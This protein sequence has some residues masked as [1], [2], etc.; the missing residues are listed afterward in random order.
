MNLQTRIPVRTRR[1][2]DQLPDFEEMDQRIHHVPK[3]V[4]DLWEDAK[5]GVPINLDLGNALR[6][7]LTEEMKESVTGF[8]I[9]GFRHV[10]IWEAG[11][12]IHYGFDPH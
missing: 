5:E 8:S 4:I 7:E 11:G 2:S 3:F 12:C 6:Y 1:F 10:V 9:Q